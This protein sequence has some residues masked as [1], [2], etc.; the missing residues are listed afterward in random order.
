[1]RQ[2]HPEVRELGIEELYVELELPPPPPDRPWVYLGMVS[3]IDGGVA[4]DGVSGGLGG[5]GDRQAF[6]GLRASADAVLVGAG[7]ARAEDYGPVSIHERFAAAR[8]RRGQS[9]APHLVVV[10]RS[11]RLDP[12]AR[13]FEEDGPLPLVLTG[14]RGAATVRGVVADDRILVTG[15]DAP[16]LATGLARLRTMGVRRLLCEGGPSLNGDLLAGSWVDEIFLTVAPQAI[17]GSAG[18]IV[19]GDDAPHAAALVSAYEHEGELLLRY[20]LSR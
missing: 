7:T 20:R 15:D 16:D 8:V 6:R 2:L 5:E 10:T 19:S 18:R 3:S 17:G 12:G 11:G 9:P 1:M 14:E 4:V 13:L